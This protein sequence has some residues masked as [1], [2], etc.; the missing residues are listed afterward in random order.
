MLPALQRQ[1]QTWHSQYLDIHKEGAI[2]I[3]VHN[4]L[5]VTVRLVKRSGSTKCR[6]QAK[7]HGPQATCQK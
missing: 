3:N 4:W 5:G 1:A 6:R 2:A 7:A